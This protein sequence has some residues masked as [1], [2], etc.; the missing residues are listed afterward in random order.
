MNIDKLNGKIAENRMNREMLAE[1][2]GI[3]RSSIYRKLDNADKITI[4]EAK[5]IKEILSL[6]DEEA[7]EIFLT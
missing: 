4:G 5:K 3:N 2:L 7:C 6:S 1:K